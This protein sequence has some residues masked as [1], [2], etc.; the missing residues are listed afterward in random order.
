MGSLLRVFKN[1][2]R[3]E[4]VKIFYIIVVL[5]VQRLSGRLEVNEGICVVSSFEGERTLAEKEIV[6]IR[7]PSI[8]SNKTI[9][10][11]KKWNLLRE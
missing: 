7:N 9:F 4:V 5:K 10:S 6:E 3:I 1:V 2:G 8:E 11:S